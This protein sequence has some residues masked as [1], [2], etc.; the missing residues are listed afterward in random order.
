MEAKHLTQLRKL[1]HAQQVSMTDDHI[2]NTVRLL[3]KVDAK[4]ALKT[5]GWLREPKGRNVDP[6]Q[7]AATKSLLA[8]P[9]FKAL[10]ERLAERTARAALDDF[11]GKVLHKEPAPAP[12]TN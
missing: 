12:S 3:K 11:F 4:D 10:E 9:S 5:I 7:S 6:K 1:I 2:E 8:H